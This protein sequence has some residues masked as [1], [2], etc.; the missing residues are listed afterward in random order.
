[1]AGC[2]PQAE[3]AQ[4]GNKIKIAIDPVTRIEGHLK[5]EVEVKNG[6]VVDAHLSG[7]MF[8]GF[9]AIFRGGGQRGS[10][11]SMRVN[12]RGGGAVIIFLLLIY[13]LLAFTKF[14]SQLVRLF[15]S[16]Q[17]EY[18]ADAIAVRL[19]RDPLSL[20]EA[21]Y[22]IGY[23][24]RGGGL[25]AQELES[26]FIVNPVYSRLDEGKGFVPDMFSTHPPLQ[27]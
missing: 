26:I 1:M 10:G 17:R 18:R 27:D 24:W 11:Y 25:P 12:A 6:K 5:A 9:E 2:K 23:R 15:I 14:L 8:R 19:T 22:A 3:P 4:S 16:R 21:L 13:S 7:G 20:A